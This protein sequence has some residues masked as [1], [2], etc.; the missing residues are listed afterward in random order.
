MSV[1]QTVQTFTGIANVNEFYGYH[2]L[3]EVFK[4]DIRA[5]IEKWQAAEE[6][7]AQPTA[8]RGVSEASKPDHRAPHKRLGG[9]SGKWFAGL[10]N[11]NRVRDDAERLHSHRA[12]H[13][14]LL[15]ALGYKLEPQQIE[16]Q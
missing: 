4:G 12:L 10:A 15:E 6:E 2:Y 11:H 14:P 8:A 9:L 3:A 13:T 16:L 1:A 7:S 5:Q